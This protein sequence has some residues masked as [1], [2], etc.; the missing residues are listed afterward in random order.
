MQATTMA[1]RPPL[2]VR[3]YG[4]T[5]AELTSSGPGQVTCRYTDQARDRWPLN[6]PLLSCSLPLT[7]RPHKNAGPFFRGVLPEGAGRLNRTPVEPRCTHPQR[8]GWSSAS[9]TAPS[10]YSCFQIQLKNW[11]TH[12]RGRVAGTSGRR[13]RGRGER[14]R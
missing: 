1:R 3:L 10:G 7:R 2:V 14:R 11:N 4:E 5:V 12:W 13:W 8:R 6:L 9:G